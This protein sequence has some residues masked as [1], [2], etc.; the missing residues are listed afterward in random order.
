MNIFKKR[1]IMSTSNIIRNK[2][3]RFIVTKSTLSSL[4]NNL[5]SSSSFYIN[6]YFSN[7][8]SSSSSS[9]FKKSTIKLG[10]NTDIPKDIMD[11]VIIGTGNVVKGMLQGI[12]FATF[13]PIQGAYNGLKDDGMIGGIKGLGIGLT[14]GIFGGAAIVASG[15]ASGVYQIG[16]GIYETPGAINAKN[17]G[18]EW[19]DNIREWKL[20]NLKEEANEFLELNDDE[21]ILKLKNNDNKF[22]KDE[23][24]YFDNNNNKKKI[25]KETGFYDILGIKS[26]ATSKD[27]KKAYYIKAK[28]NHPDIHR[29]DPNASN[30]FQKI[31]QAYQILSD[32]KL[33]YNYDSNGKDGIEENIISNNIDS[34]ILY[35]ILFGSQEFEHL[36]GELNLSYLQNNNINNK[37][38]S[39]YYEKLK[40]FHQKQREIKCAIYLA[41]ILQSFVDSNGNEELFL[42]IIDKEIKKLSSTTFGNTLLMLIG[43]CY[44]NHVKD[45]DLNFING[46]QSNIKQTF[47]GFSTRY[48]IASSGIR[49]AKNTLEVKRMSVKKSNDD[50]NDINKFNSKLEEMSGNMSSVLW[51]LTELDIT[52]TLSGVCNK[53]TYDVSVDENTRKLR[54]Q[55]LLILGNSFINCQGSTEAGLEEFKKRI[56][57]KLPKVRPTH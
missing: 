48:T 34:S 51:Y 14:K 5:L 21:Y 27:I 40:E 29:N 57:K 53:V 10:Q 23:I 39:P 17:N 38:N 24:D 15:T 25:V 46:M 54:K 28:E 33:R 2:S 47:K 55:A 42:K 36:I 41:N 3:L 26:N 12:S 43:V 32:D 16:R 30:K 11:G 49:A 45:I 20:I 37:Y 18:L 50:D 7:K 1:L 56:Y 9:I 35:E 31:S 44:T 22:N 6:R 19:D 8:S 13:A 4:N 52:K